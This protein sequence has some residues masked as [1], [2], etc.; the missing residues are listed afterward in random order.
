MAT[1]P[2]EQGLRITELGADAGSESDLE[3][4]DLDGP[5]LDRTAP[6]SEL[7]ALRDEFVDAFNAR[8]LEALLALVSADVECPDLSSEGAPA[9]IEEVDSIWERSPGALLTRGFLD[10]EPV[11]VGWLPDEDGCWT[12][13]ALVCFDATDGLLCSV[14]MPDDADALER[15][16]AEDPAGDEVEE[17]AD[18]STW[19]SGAET[20]PHPRS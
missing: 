4:V 2:T 20:V 16:E 3:A 15:A 19:E 18:W 1:M 10:D 11:A 5:S 12:R 14:A 9:L 17:W 6:D 13:A 7:E 8:D